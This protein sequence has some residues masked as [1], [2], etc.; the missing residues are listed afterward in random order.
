MNRKNE[1]CAGMLSVAMSYA[2]VLM[3][4]DVDAPWGHWNAT[5]D[6][7]LP[8]TADVSLYDAAGNRILMGKDNEVTNDAPGHVSAYVITGWG[9]SHG[10]FWWDDVAASNVTFSTMIRLKVGN[11]NR[12][13][14]GTEGTY[15][16]ADHAYVFSNFAGMSLY[17]N[18][19]SDA[20]SDVTPVQLVFKNGS[21]EYPVAGTANRL[22]RNR[23]YRLTV[24]REVAARGVGNVRIYLDDRQIFAQDGLAIPDDITAES[25][26]FDVRYW[27]KNSFIGYVNDL[28][29][30]TNA[31]SSAEVAALAAKTRIKA[32]LVGH[33]PMDEVVEKSGKR[34][35]PDISGFGNDLEIGTKTYAAQGGAVS[36]AGALYFDAPNRDS[37][38]SR[39]Q[40]LRKFRIQFQN[41]AKIAV[42]VRTPNITRTIVFPP[43]LFYFSPT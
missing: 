36:G 4:V 32:E 39:S 26:L 24:T 42:V 33:W 9:N 22:M 8:A 43:W 15:D 38:R 21:A 23:W 31:L 20:A 27:E 41:A 11:L 5:G 34:Y 40:P 3:A 30:Y 29:M 35:S 18:K 19:E 37:K 7:P 6:E 28:R 14:M 10:R 12:Y 25:C 2:S 16:T 1:I 17:M 13:G